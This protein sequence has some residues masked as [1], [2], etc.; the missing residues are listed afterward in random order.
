MEIHF[1]ISV[2][3]HS[4]SFNDAVNNG[5]ITLTPKGLALGNDVS[6]YASSGLFDKNNNEIYHKDILRSD[7]G[8]RFLVEYLTGTFFIYDMDNLK[9][10]LPIALSNLKNGNRIDMVIE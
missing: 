5:Y 7:D 10:C 4:I 6:L 3:N 8:K 9:G 1:R 2:N